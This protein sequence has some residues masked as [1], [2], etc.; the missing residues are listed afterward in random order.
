MLYELTII[1]PESATDTNIDQT[2]R[3]IRRYAKIVKREDEGVKRLAYPIHGN[4]RGRFLF[5]FLEIDRET[6]TRISDILNI[7]DNVLRYLLVR[8]D[9]K[10]AGR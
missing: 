8:A 2:E 1:A 7:D 3:M 4:D 5:Y 9:T 6:P 10:Y